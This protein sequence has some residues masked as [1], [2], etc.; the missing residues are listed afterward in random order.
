MTALATAFHQQRSF[1]RVELGVGALGLQHMR[2]EGSAKVRFPFGGQEAILINTG[3]GLAGGDDF[4]FKVEAGANAKL[5]VTSQA[6]ERVYRSLGPVAQVH[7]R[8]VAKAGAQLFWLPQETILFD[9]AAF[10]R[11]LEVEFDSSSQFIAVEPVIFGRPEAH[12]K[13]SQILFRDSWRIRVDGRLIYADDIFL[14]GAPPHSKATLNGATAMATLIY[15]GANWE[16]LLERLRTGLGKNCAAS[17]WNGKLVA[18]MVA[19][20]GFEL[21]K[22]LIPALGVVAGDIS[23]PKVWT[24]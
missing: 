13:M 5:S 12:E 2:E 11:K 19:K 16:S 24:F 15:V 17:A 4:G 18:R 23:L 7:T 10:T 21:R 14:D 20:D 1:G 6:A 3:G 8:L 22:S 9:G